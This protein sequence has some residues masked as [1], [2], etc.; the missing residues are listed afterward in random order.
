MKIKKVISLI[1][2]SCTLCLCFAGTGRTYPDPN[3][4]MTDDQLKE[5]ESYGTETQSEK[6][7][8]ILNGRSIAKIIQKLLETLEAGIRR[9]KGFKD[10]LDDF[11]EEKDDSLIE[12]LLD[13]ISNFSNNYDNKSH[14]LDQTISGNL[15]NNLEN[16][17]KKIA[18]KL[19][20]PVRLTDGVYEQNETDFSTGNTN[21]IEVTRKY[22]STVQTSGSF[23]YG[24]ETNLD[25]RI[26]LGIDPIEKLYQ[27]IEALKQYQNCLNENVGKLE[28]ELA[29]YYKVS[30]IYNAESEIR[31]K[32]N[33]IE[34]DLS[35]VPF[36]EIEAL[37][38]KEKAQ[39]YYE[40]NLSIQAQD[41][42]Y[43]LEHYKEDAQ[44][45]IEKL[46]TDINLARNDAQKLDELKNE[47]TY[48]EASLKEYNRRIQISNERKAR[49]VRVRLEGSDKAFEE[50][51]T[52]TITFIDEN[53]VPHVLYETSEG[54]KVKDNEKISSGANDILAC[55]IVQN[56]EFSENAYYV[57]KFRNGSKNYYDSY[58]LF[59]GKADINNNCVYINR[60]S[61]GKI[62]NIKNSDG[63][64]LSFE[65]KN[66]RVAKITNVRSPE[67]N[68]VYTYSGN[69]LVCVKDTD[70]DIVTMD[71]DSDGRMTSLNKCDGSSVRFEYGEQTSDGKVLTTKTTNEEGHSERF[72]YFRNDRRTDYI[73]HDG[74][75]TSYFYDEH[76]RTIKEIRADGSVIQ[77]E[78]DNF[79]NLIKVNENGNITRLEYDESGNRTSASYSDGSSEKW[80]YDRF[81]SVTSY[82]DRDGVKQEILRD[83]NGNVT[84][85]K[86]GGKSVYLQEVNPKGQVINRTVFGQNA[87]YTEY[88]YDAY[89][90][91][92]SETCGR[93]KTEYEY[94]SR[95]RIKKVIQGGKAI[96]EY[97]Y[98]NIP[99]EGNKT[100]ENRIIR[101][102]CNGLETVYVTNGRKDITKVIQKDTVT[103][104]VHE[105]RIEYDRR[106]L[107]LK[108][109]SGNGETEKTVSGY[110]YT[111]E[112]NLKAEVSYGNE[113]RIKVYEYKNGQISEI[114]Q[115]KTASLNASEEITEQKISQLLSLA[116][117]KVYSR[118][119]E[120][121]ILNENKKLLT[122]TDALGSSSLFEYDSYGNLVKTTD[123]N[124]EIR[125]N[126]FTRG[127]RLTAEQNS[128][129]GWY[130]YGYSTE[131]FMNKAGEQN[132]T[133]VKA[134]YY[135]DGSIRY[136]T[137]RY[138][139]TTYYNYDSR[140]R[141]ESIQSE[142]KKIWYEY[143]KFDRITKQTVGS[144]PD[145]YNCVYYA[146][147][148]Y[149]EDGRSVRVTEGGKYR[150]AY[151]L[152][153]FGNVIKQTD[154]NNNERSFVYDSLNQMTESYDG[155]NNKTEYEYNAPGTVSKIILPDGSVTKYEYNCMGQISKVT[156]D[157][158]IVYTASYDRAG[159]LVKERSRADSEKTYEYDKAGRVTKVLCGGE[160]LESYTYG[161]NNRTVTVKDGNGNNYL[162]N[163][164]SYGRLVS[165]KNRSGLEQNYF[166]D[167]G[168]ELKSKNSF[169]GYSTTINY[170]SDRTV[171]TV[172]YSDGSEN[173]FVYD[174]LGNIIEAEN[175]Y[176]KTEYSYDKG[177]RLILQKEITV[178]EEVAFEY[179]AAGNRTKLLS[180]N[181]ETVY[182]Y[183][184][185]NEV[186]EV[187]DNKQRLKISLSYDVNSREIKR[188]FGNGTCEETVYDKA[189]RIIV[190]TQKDIHGEILWGEG[191]VYGEDGKRSA[192]V[193]N[194][195]RVTF[196]EYNNKGQI[197]SVYYP[198]TNEM[199]LKFKDEAEAYGVRT[200]GDD[201]S[202][203]RF[204]TMKEKNELSEVLNLMQYTYENK[205]TALQV[206]LKE[207]Y[208]YDNNG[209]R[210]SKTIPYG[211]INYTYDRENCLL[212]AGSRGEVYVTYT[213]DKM[214]NLLTE[215]SP[216][217]VTK[218][219]YNSQ[220]RL[221]YCEVTDKVAM[222]YSQ[223]TYAYDAFGRRILVQ[224]RA[225]ATLR[226]LYDGLTFDVIK[227]SPTLANGMFTDSLDTG[228]HYSR[229]GRPTGDR[230]RYI[231]DEEA[232]FGE[233]YRYID[234]NTYKI[235]NGRYRGERI[236]ISVNGS[237][238]AQATS[239]DG[240]QYFST[241]LLGSVASVTDNYGN[242]KAGYSYD[243]FGA[244]VQ[245]DLS[246]STDFGYLGKQNDTSSRLY[247]YGYRDYK[248]QLARFTTV[249]PIRDGTNW[250]V[251]C[252]GDAVNFVDLWGLSATDRVGDDLCE[253]DIQ[254]I[255]WAFIREVEG[256]KLTGY[257]PKLGTSNSG[258]TIAIGFD[259]GQQNIYDLNRIF[260]IGNENQD[261]KDLYF[262]YLSLKQYEAQAFLEEHP[263][264]ISGPQCDRTNSCVLSG[265]VTSIT[266]Y[267]EENFN[268]SFESLNGNIQTAL[269]SITYQNGNAVVT[270][271]LMDNILSGDYNEAADI[272][273]NYGSD[274]YRDRRIKEANLI[275]QVEN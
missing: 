127:G 154:G 28:S 97:S 149:S 69:K 72:E 226:T 52:D 210:T 4:G 133:P 270:R 98:E 269:F 34:S 83:E 35:E 217:K 196:Y 132:G 182:S 175:V 90:N 209:N 164:D 111:K 59:I 188:T 181:R 256:C 5:I 81:G 167:E 131:G 204:L 201:L 266:N 250:L 214:G 174:M 102:D 240:I 158:G 56:N 173:R 45:G 263:L 91:L 258:V 191:Y 41:E 124:G 119:C 190:K 159:R 80:T 82:T 169:D 137:D 104:T 198:Y 46:K 221:I 55:E 107:P 24:W 251:Y 222:E 160:V 239:D 71:Y 254:S 7:K 274:E 176:G 27:V 79:G 199:L 183:G 248:T 95:N 265:Y 54:W 267:V 57:V 23:G 25:S 51:G 224:D 117:D 122:I 31:E 85:F 268:V 194:T 200:L 16:A 185:N 99:A 76:H 252:N 223:S 112:G 272:I 70:G 211:T 234:D 20:D 73:D 236:Q 247:N 231:S 225:E 74:N 243:A 275:R 88:E 180:A 187:F 29:D 1:L 155:Y 30:S 189:G 192:T 245:G 120:I 165:E 11:T 264:I 152:D 216:R 237:I 14:N 118:K 125:Q 130:E 48:N 87:V 261:L 22:Q 36:M 228:I 100:G 246:G 227:Q 123:G 135:P 50:T 19:G 166:Y 66:N 168:G 144:S 58:G 235:V 93:I 68:A 262:P 101:K 63:E 141:T 21:R 208:V 17:F 43:E 53:S 193:D 203:T 197:E 253:S 162:Y 136:M 78:Y 151:Q 186:K 213:Y 3:V 220:N 260:G 42:Y 229:T 163:Y 150:T 64:E 26:I 109:Y 84:G 161:T 207:S 108:V 230:Y 6:A 273:H 39:S 219:A 67:E 257:V 60:N 145:E 92:I 143:D 255:D 128:F 61:D 148:E 121:K 115:F 238:A 8:E 177:G 134:E 62:N 242:R 147:Y 2:L 114:K 139:K 106:H 156:D 142:G 94:D 178:N 184:R 37:D 9:R 195:G 40:Y 10:S 13:I 96:S 140:G 146:E 33:I 77:N 44:N 215:E 138:G 75:R 47:I 172:H 129:G 170:S 206:L 49:N 105:T 202:E 179:D 241:D 113:S 15:L 103:G 116:G 126:K 89:G 271:E 18:Q 232:H 233:R 110:L 212:T 259:L 65:Y 171:R 86:N 157:C 32:I 153:A 244:L 12:A 205:L 249:D 38:V 218:Y